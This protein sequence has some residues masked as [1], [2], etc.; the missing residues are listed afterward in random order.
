MKQY[1]EDNTMFKIQDI[2]G[3]DIVISVP[4]EEAGGYVKLMVSHDVQE[5]AKDVLM[6]LN[7]GK[8]NSQKTYL[9]ILEKFDH[10]GRIL[11]VADL[12]QEMKD[13]TYCAVCAIGGLFVSHIVKK[14][15]KDIATDSL[16]HGE[17]ITDLEEIFSRRELM[18][19]EALFE[20]WEVYMLDYKDAS[21]FFN[22]NF[23]TKT[24]RMIGIMQ[25]L[26]SNEGRLIINGQTLIK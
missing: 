24:E 5:L 8:Y 20:D 4:S 14:E 9:S 25:N 16:T 19:I 22:D 21:D 26:I 12:F 1:L 3:S 13:R 11:F 23:I 18:L 6:Q 2:K 17:M 15:V 7:L 10:S